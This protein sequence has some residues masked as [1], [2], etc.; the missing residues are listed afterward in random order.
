MAFSQAYTLFMSKHSGCGIRPM[1]Y[2]SQQEAATLSLFNESLKSLSKESKQRPRK[3]TYSPQT[4]DGKKYYYFNKNISSFSLSSRSLSPFL[5]SH[6]FIFSSF[7]LILTFS[8]SLPFVSTATTLKATVAVGHGSLLTG[9]HQL[10]LKKTQTS[11][12]KNSNLSRQIRSLSA[13]LSRWWRRFA[14]GLV[15][16]VVA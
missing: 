12:S 11:L 13:K 5:S 2:V 10:S 1:F 8:F 7:S 6:F 9:F 3:K 16:V 14:S 4:E 15:V